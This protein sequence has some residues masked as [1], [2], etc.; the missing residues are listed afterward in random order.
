MKLQRRQFLHLT[1]GAA[2]APAFSRG[3]TAQAYPTRPIT[4][5]VPFPA[6]GPSDAVAR[7]LAERMRASLGQ[8]IIIENVSGADGSIGTGR[9]AR[10]RPDGYTI[11]LG[12]ISTHVLNGAFYSLPYDVTGVRLICE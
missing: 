3:A 6:G 9:A 2:I 1:A 12:F 10:A 7:V 8:P 5:I 11:D 4:M